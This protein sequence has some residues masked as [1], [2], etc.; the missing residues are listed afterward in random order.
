MRSLT[1]AIGDVHGRLDLL[2]EAVSSIDA[3]SGG[4]Y[5]RIVLLGDYVDRG[6]NSRGVVDYLITNA[7]RLRMVCLKGNHEAMMV[8][9]IC[10]GS[11]SSL[12]QWMFH[13]GEETLKSYGWTGRHAPSGSL[14]PRE[15]LDWMA[16][17]PLT[18]RECHRLYVHAGLAP[19]Q[20]IQDQDEQA[21]LWIRN[22]FLESD[23]S[24]VGLHVV[25][26]HT[27]KWRGKP[28]TSEVERLPHRTNLDTG[29]YAT[30]VL[31][32]GVF[33]SGRP[34]GPTEILTVR[35]TAANGR[36]VAPRWREIV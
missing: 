33:E 34:G 31:A 35:A 13:G 6:P 18:L 17:L 2:L 14:V 9:A 15:H 26:G 29:A 25:H 32:V 22:R 28:E 19:E 10:G 23:L 24:G 20:A 36:P 11:L 12:S 30:G 5:G 7:E 4:D 8:E 16:R 1:Y 3:H 27:P 21:F